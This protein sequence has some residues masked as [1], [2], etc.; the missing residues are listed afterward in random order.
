[1]ASTEDAFLRHRVV[2][3]VCVRVSFDV[4]D[5]LKKIKKIYKSIFFLSQINHNKFDTK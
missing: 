5:Y 2:I 3:I 1:M 4:V